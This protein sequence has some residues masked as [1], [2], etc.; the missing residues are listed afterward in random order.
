M[1]QENCGVCSPLKRQNLCKFLSYGPLFLILLAV[2]CNI[3]L[4][5]DFSEVIS[6]KNKKTKLNIDFIFLTR[7]E[8]MKT[9][10]LC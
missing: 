7:T 8:Q 6:Q 2:E 3:A 4:N 9:R 1:E 10:L 5:C